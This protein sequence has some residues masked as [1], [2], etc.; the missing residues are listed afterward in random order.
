MPARKL[1]RRTRAIVRRPERGATARQLTEEREDRARSCEGERPRGNKMSFWTRS[2]A[3]AARPGMSREPGETQA[4]GRAL[5]GSVRCDSLAPPWTSA[6][7]ASPTSR[8]VCS[9]KPPGPGERVKF[10]DVRAAAAF[11]SRAAGD[12]RDGLVL[13]PAR[14]RARAPRRRGRGERLAGALVRAGWCS[15]AP[16]RGELRWWGRPVSRRRASARRDGFAAMEA[17]P[18]THW[19]EIQLVGEDGEGIPGQRY[20]IVAPD[21]RRVARLHRLPRRRA[22]EPDPRR[23]L[24]GLSPTSTPKRGSRRD[25]ARRADRRAVDF[26][27]SCGLSRRRSPS[28]WSRSI[29]DFMRRA[30]QVYGERVGVFDEPCSRPTPLGR[31]DLRKRL[32]AAGA[33]AQAAGL[34]A[35]GVGFGERVAIVSHNAARMLVSFFGVAGHGRVLVPINFRLSPAE[36]AYIVEHS[37]PSMLLVDPELDEA[38]AAGRSARTGSCSATETDA[39]AV[40]PRASSPAALGSADED[41]T[42]TINYTSGTTARPKGVQLTHR[43]LWINATTFGWHTRRHATATCTC[44]RCRCSTATAGACPSRSPR[45]GAPQ[46]VLRKVDGAEILR[47]IDGPRRHPDV[48]RARRVSTRS[49]TAPRRGTAQIPGR[50][51]HPHRGGRG[52]AAHRGRSSASRPSSGWEFIQIYGLDRDVAAADHQPHARGVGRASTADERA[53]ELGPRGRAG[54]GRRRS[55]V[56]ARGRGAGAAATRCSTAT[57]RNPTATD[58][59]LAG[60]VVPHRRRR[61]ASTTRATWRISDRK[62]DVI[63]SGGENVSSI[64]VEDALCSHPAV[65]EAGRRSACPTRSGARR[66]RRSSCWR[67]GSRPPRPELIAHCRARAGPLQVPDLG[68]AARRAGAH[69]HRQAA[70]VQAAAPLLGGPR[71]ARSTD[72]GCCCR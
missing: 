49:S 15:R 12:P 68:R 51:T 56:D 24:P 3:V 14:R 47:R 28:C 44:T 19:V 43:N 50:G 53:P 32:A 34:D 66:S 59:A 71:R 5:L 26:V 60:R 23:H 4:R 17:G 31:A 33:R 57:G 9:G 67:P 20:R 55:S 45:M 36:I 8:F 35:L 10:V 46:L 62:K 37:G 70:E 72:R 29:L 38:L 16:G 69:R 52:A 41:A 22:A 30:E 6:R 40:A 64:E 42:A 58:E 11:V 27:R 25:R 2:G 1:R 65:A 18:P 21:G 54:A 61:R 7:S 13:R 39:L 63:I 48:R